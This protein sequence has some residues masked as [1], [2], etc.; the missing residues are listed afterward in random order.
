MGSKAMGASVAGLT[1]LLSKE[2][3][4]LVLIAIVPAVVAAWFV[5]NW[6][7]KDFVYRIELTPFIFIGCAVAAVVIAWVTVSYQSIKAAKVNPVSSLRYE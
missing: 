7:L 4:K 6:W 2:F 3:T 5:A 1:L